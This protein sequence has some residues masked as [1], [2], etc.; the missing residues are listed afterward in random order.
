MDLVSN[1]NGFIFDL[2]G[3]IYRE[4]QLIHKANEVVNR[5]ISNGKKF[6]FLSNRTTSE[7]EIYSEKLNRFDIR[8]TPNDIIT[9]AEITSDY[10]AENHSNEKVFVIGENPL[11]KCLN[12]SG[13]ET[14][15]VISKIDIVL[16]SLDRTLTFEKFHIAQNALKRGAR[17]FAANT[18][19]TCPIEEDEIPDAGATIAALERLT[20]RKLEMN[21]GKPSRLMIERALRKLGIP[22]NECL[23]VGDRL[24]TDIAMGNYF[25]IDTALVLSGV[26]PSY[27]KDG[28]EIEPTFIIHDISKLI[29]TKKI[30]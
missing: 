13:I 4:N 19:L 22:P 12:N 30:I 21:F 11:I 28:R 25:G 1:Y 27:E 24:D 3:T 23:I 8:C 18:D 7:I 26:T 16:I 17:F 9:S 20:N 29:D 14:T 15:D 10:L 2:D 6:V 5:V